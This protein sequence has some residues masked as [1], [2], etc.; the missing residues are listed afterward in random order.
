MVE[1]G[2]NPQWNFAGFKWYNKQRMP[3]LIPLREEIRTYNKSKKKLLAEAKGKFVLIKNNGVVDTYTNYED[4][5]LEGYKLFGNTP[6]LVKEITEIE[7]IKHFAHPL[8]K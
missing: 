4:A 5:L 8:V 6:F 1:L 2:L 3:S 7:E